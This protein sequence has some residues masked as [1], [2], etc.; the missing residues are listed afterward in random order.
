MGALPEDNR[1]SI[2]YFKEFIFEN[3]P[4]SWLYST[5]IPF[6]GTKPWINP[7]DLE[8][9]YFVTTLELIIH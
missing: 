5:F 2:K 6:P 4:D 7:E 1:E 8:L 3:K 9:K